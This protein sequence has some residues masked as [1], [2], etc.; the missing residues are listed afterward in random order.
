MVKIAL[1]GFSGA[2]KDTI[3]DILV[4]NHGFKK[5]NFASALKDVLSAIFGWDRTMLE[6][7]TVEDR[8][9]RETVDE[10]WSKHLGIPNLT[11][12]MMM[13]GI[14]TGLFR[15]KFHPD[16]WVK[17]VERKL[18]FEDNIVITDCRFKNE[19]NM[20]KSYGCKLIFIERNKPVWFDFY[21]NGGNSE[22]ANKLHESERSWI[23]EDFDLV[24]NNNIDK[25]ELNNSVDTILIN[26]TSLSIPY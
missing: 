12:R 8:I 1:C 24:F 2:G 22:E 6:G 15:D 7:V 16:I 9:K 13:I 20:V 10:W 18:C 17:S 23:R 4:K 25:T 3:A 11:P 21:K 19:I 14:G 5:V 26:L